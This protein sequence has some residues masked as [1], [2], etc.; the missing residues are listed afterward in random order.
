MLG[1]MIHLVPARHYCIHISVSQHWGDGDRWNLGTRCLASLA[2][3]M[4]P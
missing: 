3:T 2:K 1:K 4:S